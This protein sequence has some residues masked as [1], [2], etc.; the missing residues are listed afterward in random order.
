M[1]EASEFVQMLEKRQGV[2]ISAPEEIAFRNK[3]ISKDQ[4]IEAAK[5]Y[6]KSPYGKHLM[7]VANGKYVY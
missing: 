1:I 3:W 4:L 7:N 6:G 5:K 2:K